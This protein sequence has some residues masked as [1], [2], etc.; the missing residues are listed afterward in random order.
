MTRIYL[1]DEDY[2][3]INS[4]DVERIKRHFN[5]LRGELVITRDA[6]KKIGKTAKEARDLIDSI[7]RG[8]FVEG[9][10]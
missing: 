9:A 5:E 6:E 2:E 7:L 10:I 4:G 1:T 3:V 8:G